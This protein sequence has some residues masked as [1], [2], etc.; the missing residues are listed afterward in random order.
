M[1]TTG[2]KVDPNNQL[3]NLTWGDF[4]S[5]LASSIQQFRT[6]GDLVDVTLS[7][8]GRSF[9]AHKIVLSAAS[10]FLLDLLKN[11]SCNHPILVLAGVSPKDMEALLEFIYHG[12]VSVDPDHLPSLLQAAQCLSIQ[13]L[14]PGA[15]HPD[16]KFEETNQFISKD[17]INMLF[18]SKSKKKSKRKSNDSQSGHG[19]KKK[20]S[21]DAE[22]STAHNVACN[23]I[24]FNS[25]NSSDETSSV[26]GGSKIRG[27]SD[28]P[29]SC[30]FC[31]ATLRQARNLRRHL[32]MLHFGVGKVPANIELGESQSSNSPAPLSSDSSSTLVVLP[33]ALC[34]PVMEAAE[35]PPLPPPPVTSLVPDVSACLQPAS[36]VASSF[37]S[38]SHPESLIDPHPSAFRGVGIIPRPDPGSHSEV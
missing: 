28:Q 32:E 34:Q 7:A 11:A 29:T 38:Y 22:N 37:F 13:G 30:P 10:P 1:T 6:Q 18:A 27:A 21:S 4:S 25:E 2:E 15:L 12:E 17:A 35:P 3:Y 36:T 9:P 8:G 19:H 33:S 16:I 20:R 31:G 23:Q 5:S 26:S 24:A 14:A